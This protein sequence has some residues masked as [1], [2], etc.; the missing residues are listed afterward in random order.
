M[1]RLAQLPSK[2]F[3]LR[4]SMPKSNILKISWSRFNCYS[5]C[6]LQYY[7]RYDKRIRMPQP[8]TPFLVGLAV[9]RAVEAWVNRRYPSNYIET[10]VGRTFAGLAEGLNVTTDKR[11]EYLRRSVKGAMLA[12]HT[13]R[14]LELEDH[15]ARI[16]EWFNV[17]PKEFAANHRL[18][19]GFDIFD[20]VTKT[21]YDLKMHTS[22][23]TSDERQLHTYAVA[24]DAIGDKVERV[25]YITP[26]LR[27]KVTTKPIDYDT[28]RAH[29]SVMAQ[30]AIGMHLGQ[31]DHEPNPD[32]H[33][34]SCEF[35]KTR[36]C[37]V[38]YERTANGRTA[39]DRRVTQTEG[40]SYTG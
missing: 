36:Y 26:L 38:T 2:L 21:V 30:A 5:T 7:L 40:Q 31:Y 15:K 24:L 29:S 33:C 34:F 25:G 13:Y 11:N 8:R 17:K 10:E 4:V 3:T 27:K 12:E 22:R 18:V 20:P 6:G 1:L 35:N 14:A 9:H 37:S 23:N 39:K 16:E 28:I 19:G 32:S